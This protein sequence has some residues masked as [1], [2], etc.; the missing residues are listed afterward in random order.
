MFSARGGQ[1]I[2]S[3]AAMWSIFSAAFSLIKP[4]RTAFSSIRR[5]RRTWT[6]LRYGES[7]QETSRRKKYDHEA[8]TERHLWK[9]CSTELYSNSVELICKTIE[10]VIRFLRNNTRG[11][12]KSGT[13]PE[14][15]QISIVWPRSRT[16]EN[17]VR[18]NGCGLKDETNRQPKQKLT[19]FK[20]NRVNLQDNR[21]VIRTMRNNGS[22]RAKS[23]HSAGTTSD[24]YCSTAVRTKNMLAA[25]MKVAWKMKRITVR[26]KKKASRTREEGS[27]DW[28]TNDGKSCKEKEQSSISK[29]SRDWR[30]S[31]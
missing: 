13:Q 17:V 30:K 3:N 18:N 4:R 21:N 23:G 8:F 27:P 19:L 15:P 9:Q 16:R 5:Q 2:L 24:F 6:W 11:V 7:V 25:I 1:F 31:K 14:R 22:R 10:H 26:S 20:Y 12:A 29:G 28:Q